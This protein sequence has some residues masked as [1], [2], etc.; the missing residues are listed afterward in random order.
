MAKVIGKDAA[1]NKRC[2]CKECTSIV[3]YTP[4][5]IKRKNYKDI[6]QTSCTVEY[7]TCPE[8]GNKIVLKES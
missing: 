1:L 3:E 6:S 2:T 5:E 4:F 8:C 7:I